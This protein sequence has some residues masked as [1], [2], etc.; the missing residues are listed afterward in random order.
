LLIVEGTVAE[1][2]ARANDVPTAWIAAVTALTDRSIPDDA[3]W[4]ERAGQF[5]KLFLDLP[6]C[7]GWIILP[8][9][10]NQD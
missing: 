7:V 3:G 8:A 4:L 5:D 10:D 9:V 1:L 6:R 2:T